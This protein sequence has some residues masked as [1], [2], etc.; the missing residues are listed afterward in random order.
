MSLPPTKVSPLARFRREMAPPSHVVWQTQNDDDATALQERLGQW[1]Q[2][3]AKAEAL[4]K[5]HVYENPD[6]DASDFI[7]H[8]IILYQLLLDGE[9][10]A[11]SYLDFA[12]RTQKKE[13]VQPTL[14]LVEQKTNALFNELVSWHGDLA[15]Q[16]DI[17]ESFKNS[18]RE[19]EEGKI[20][21]FDK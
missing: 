4:F 1:L 20:L 14:R 11:L 12:F 16:P 17:P 18:V 2:G 5:N 6:V 19:V 7:Q 15:S 3:I 9:W 21:D 10:L 13:E 8:R